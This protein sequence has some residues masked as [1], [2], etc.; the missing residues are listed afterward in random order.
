[1]KAMKA[2]QARRP[3]AATA[4]PH[5]D[6]ATFRRGGSHCATAW[7]GQLQLLRTCA[8]RSIALPCVGANAGFAALQEM[9]YRWFV[10]THIYDVEEACRKPLAQLFGEGP[11]SPTVHIGPVEGDILRV[12]LSRLACPDGLVSGP[13]CQFVAGNGFSDPW[14]HPGMLVFNRV[15]AWIEYFASQTLKFFV[16]ENVKGLSKNFQNR[17]SIL[18]LSEQRLRRR[19]PD[20]EIKVWLLNSKDYT[21]AQHRERI[22]IIGVRRSVLH[23]AGNRAIPDSPAPA[24]ARCRLSWFLTVGAPNTPLSSLTKRQRQ[25]LK[26]YKKLS[27]RLIRDRN[28]QGKLMTCDLSR[29]PSAVYGPKFCTDDLVGTLLTSNRQIFLVSLGEGMRSPTVH[30]WLKSE[31]RCRLQGFR[32]EMFADLNETERLLLVGNAFAVPC[33]GVTLHYITQ[34]LSNAV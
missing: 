19:C 15:L 28:M 9:G 26:D 14:S 20:F 8:A 6:E 12:E 3:V 33:I 27:E 4:T 29:R 25:N 24:M 11:G 22:Y 17:G 34:L 21:L 2:R 13:P 23:Q 1:M 32:P 18:S 30:R 31:E 16:V 10:P 7:V 5:M